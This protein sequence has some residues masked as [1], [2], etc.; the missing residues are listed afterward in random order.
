VAVLTVPR[1][2]PL[3]AP[4]EEQEGAVRSKIEQA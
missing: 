3:D 4:L 1:H 2:L